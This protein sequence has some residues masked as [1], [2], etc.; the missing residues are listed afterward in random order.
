MPKPVYIICASGLSEDRATNLVSLFGIIESLVV[1]SDPIAEVAKS[2][3]VKREPKPGDLGQLKVM[4]VWMK[5]SDADVDV[6][7]EHEFVVQC[8]D[9]E[10]PPIGRMEFTFTK[11]AYL[12][13]FLLCFDGLPPVTRDGFAVI[14]SQIRRDGGDWLSQ[15]YPLLI[16]IHKPEDTGQKDPAPAGSLSDLPDQ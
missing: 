10:L 2:T 16:V 3:Q 8:D 14:R 15:E 13:R 7:F 5:T 4:A 1:A 9:V 6:T 12:K 11:D